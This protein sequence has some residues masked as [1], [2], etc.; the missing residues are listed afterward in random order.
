MAHNSSPCRGVREEIA[1]GRSRRH[2]ALGRQRRR[3]PGPGTG[4]R[5]WAGGGHRRGTG[6]HSLYGFPELLQAGKAF[7]AVLYAGQGHVF[8]MENRPIANFL[9]SYR[10][11]APER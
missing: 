3:Q 11:A 7:E 9:V 8:P 10:S 5:K 2:R 1:R 6:E 4:R